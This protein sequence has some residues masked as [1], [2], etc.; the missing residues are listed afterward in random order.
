VLA[1]SP[2][3]GQCAVHEQ[4]PPQKMEASYNR[5]YQQ[6]CQDLTGR[7]KYTFDPH[8]SQR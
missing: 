2:P 4:A 1:G 8:Q 5:E 7:D 6:G 3:E